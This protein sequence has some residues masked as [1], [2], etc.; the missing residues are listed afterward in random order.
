MT[1]QFSWS[2]SV[3]HIQVHLYMYLA[4]ANLPFIHRENTSF[5][6]CNIGCKTLF[7]ERSKLPLKLTCPAGT[8]TCPATLLS[9]GEI[10]ICPKHYLPSGASQ[11]LVQLAPLLA[12]ESYQYQNH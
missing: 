4:K 6:G 10:G 2:H 3:C 12:S 9:K 7:S 11:G 8:F 5:A 1:D